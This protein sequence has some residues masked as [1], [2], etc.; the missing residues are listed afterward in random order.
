MLEERKVLKMGFMKGYGSQRNAAMHLGC[1]EA[2]ISKVVSRERDLA[3]D[4]MPKA[5]KTHLIIGISVAEDAT[6]YSCL[7]YIEGDRHPQTMIRRVEK[8]DAEADAALRKLPLM[9]LDKHTGA[10]LTQE[11]REHATL[12]GWELCDRIRADLN[13]VAELDDRYQLGL[14]SYL[15]ERKRPLAAAR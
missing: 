7:S 1:S 10:D 11:E 8:E 6:G 3:P 15:T 13:L 9:L 14:V 12:T 2:L 5:S 4:L